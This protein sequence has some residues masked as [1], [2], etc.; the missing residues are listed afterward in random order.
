MPNTREKLVELLCEVIETDGCNGHCNFPPCYLVKACADNLIENGATVQQWISVKDRLPE[1]D[2]RVLVWMQDNEEGYTQM[3][4]D[5]WSCTMEQGH[6]WIRWG[7]CVTH[8]MPLPTPP[9]RAQDQKGVTCH[10]CNGT[11]EPEHYQNKKYC[12]NCGAGVDV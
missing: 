12:P 8:W 2:V 9:A 1:K 6:H 4:T 11:D 7:K 10:N 3:D 5:R